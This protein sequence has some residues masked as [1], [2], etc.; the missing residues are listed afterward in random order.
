MRAALGK[1]KAI[2]KY[3]A[4]HTTVVQSRPVLANLF[5]TRAR[6][7]QAGHAL[8]VEDLVD[9]LTLKDNRGNSRQD[10][11]FALEKL[12]IDSVCRKDYNDNFRT[13]VRHC[14]KGESR[15]R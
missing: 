2:D 3:I 15:L 11:F 10:P 9:V 1:G 8:V 7:L 5:E 13:D 12:V 6:Q 14:P 4:E